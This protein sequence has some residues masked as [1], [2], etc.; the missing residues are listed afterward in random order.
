MLFIYVR[1]VYTPELA[2]WK[3]EVGAW[4]P[5]W[6]G[7]RPAGGTGTS[8]ARPCLT[9]WCALACLGVRPRRGRGWREYEER[10]ASAVGTAVT[11]RSSRAQGLRAR[12]C[13]RR[14][15]RSWLRATPHVRAYSAAAAAVPAAVL[16]AAAVAHRWCCTCVH[17]DGTEEAVS[18]CRI[19]E[20]FIARAV[21]KSF[22]HAS[23]ISRVTP[24][25]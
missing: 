25:A 8:S 13:R 21:A 16:A 18:L 6:P 17:K 1:H 24:H 15:L 23:Y 9:V 7:S 19:V 2:A 3:A 4:P 12:R 22:R 10:G 11:A 20:L 14:R 5:R